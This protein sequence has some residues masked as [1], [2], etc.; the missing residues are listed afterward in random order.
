MINEYIN[1][2]EEWCEVFNL[3]DRFSKG[4]MTVCK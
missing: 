3:E 2:V 4:K 1:F